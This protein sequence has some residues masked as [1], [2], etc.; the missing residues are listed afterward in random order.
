MIARASTQASQNL[1]YLSTLNKQFCTQVINYKA[2]KKQGCYVIC[3]ANCVTHTP[4][5]RNK[6]KIKPRKLNVFKALTGLSDKT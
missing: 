3:V 1:P 6:Q 4:K 2:N 5:L